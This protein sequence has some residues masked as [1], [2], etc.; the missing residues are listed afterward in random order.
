MEYPPIVI[1]RDRAIRRASV[2]ISSAG[3]SVIAAAHSGDLACPSVLPL[4]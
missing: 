1:V 2:R 4:R 3:T